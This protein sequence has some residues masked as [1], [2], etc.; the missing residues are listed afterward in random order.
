MGTQIVNSTSLWHGSNDNSVAASAAGTG[1]SFCFAYSNGAGV[2]LNHISY[3]LGPHSGN[4]TAG[5]GTNTLTTAPTDFTNTF[6][7]RNF[8]NYCLSSNLKLAGTGDTSS[9]SSTVTAYSD[10]YQA[11]ITLALE[12]LL[13]GG[14]GGWRGVCV[15][16]YSSQYVMDNTNGAIC[17]AA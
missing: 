4:S 16:Y 17:Y 11:T 7:N 2:Q 12:E 8:D 6:P 13:T 15:V 10:G 9:L 14:S 5:S 1:L 3:T